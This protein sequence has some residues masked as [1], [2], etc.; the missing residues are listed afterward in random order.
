MRVHRVI[1]WSLLATVAGVLLAALLS[2]WLLRSD[3]G[4][5]WLLA[6][7]INVLPAGATLEWERIDGTLSGPLEIRD[8]HYRHEG[9]RF[10]A[11]R[12]RIDH[13]IWPLLSRRL[14]IHSLRL[15]HALLVL[16]VDDTP[17]EL[18]RW[19]DVL[20][21]LDL[22]VTVSVDKL[23]V[24]DLQV[25]RVAQSLVK[26]ERI[27]GGLDLGRGAMA[28][29]G[30]RLRSDRGRLLVA[31]EYLPRDNFRTA[32][33]G[34]VVFPAKPGAAAAW[35][36]L[37]VRGD[38]DYFVL[39]LDGRAPSPV[40][41]RLRLKDG[42]GRP[43]WQ[44]D[45]SSTRLLAA[46]LGLPEDAPYAFD[47]HALG[48]GGAATLR[49]RIARGD[50]SVAIEP[51]RLRLE[52]GVLSAAPLALR[53]EQGPL[54][55][56]GSLAL[57][58][59]SPSFDLVL[60][61][62]GLD[63]RPASAEQGAL[64]VRATGRVQVRG[65]WQAWTVAGAASLLRDR[66][67]A[68]LVLDGRGDARHLSLTS[69]TAST[70]TGRLQGQGEL[71]WQPRLSG[72][73]QADLGGFDPG[74][75]FPDYPGALNGRIEA[76]AA[77]DPQGRWQGT[78]SIANLRG[79]LRKRPLQGQARLQFSGDSG[80]GQLALRI[81][82]SRVEAGGRFGPNLDLQAAFAPLDLADLWPAAGGRLQ[83]RVTVRGARAAPAYAAQL[84]GAGLRWGDWS[85]ASLAANGQLPAQG[86]SGSL[87]VSASGFAVAGE[88]FDKAALQLTGSVASFHARA[89]LSAGLGVL[90]IEATAAGAGEQWQ[91]RLEQLRLAPRRGAAWRLQSAAG[92]RY[93]AGA[94][95][96]DR[97]CLRATSTDGELCAQASNTQAT[98]TGRGFPL[99]L[100]EPWLPDSALSI[101]PF[102]EL[103]LDGQ[104]NRNG[105]G[106]WRGRL[107]A[108]SGSGG[109]RLEGA[110][111]REVF[112][113]SDLRLELQLQQ[114]ELT[115]SLQASL[116]DG[117]SITGNAR[118]K[119]AASAPLQG[120]VHVQTRALDW[121]ELLSTDLASP[122]GMLDGKLVLAGELDAPRLSGDARLSQFSADLPSLGLN[123]KAGDFTLHGDA[124]GHARM[125]GQLAS[126]KGTLRVDG[127]WNLRQPDSPLE[128]TLR[129]EDITVAQTPDLDATMSPDLR[130]SYTRGRLQI[131][132]NVLVPGARVDLERLD[133]SV[134]PSADVVV[135]DPREPGA[136]SA[137][138]VDT[139]VQLRLGSAVRLHGFGLDG[140]LTGSL[141]VSDRPERPAIANGVL[142]IAGTYDAYGRALA[143]RRGRLSYVN[144]PYDDP[145]L[146]IQA[147]REF[148]QVTVGV[149]VRGTAHAPET[150]VTSQPAMTNAEALSWLL[151]G[152]PLNSASGEESRRI[153]ASA[154]ALSAGSNLLAQKIGSRLGLDS[155]GITETRAL[156][157]STFLVGK[158]I[159]PRLFVSYGLS[160]IGSGQVITLKY[161]LRHG[162]NVSVESS[163]VEAAAALNW[164]KEK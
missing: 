61:S 78:A 147:E 93:R 77:R 46:Q 128:L 27:D 5:D 139:D 145:T 116:P 57:E 98:L 86:A 87:R 114:P 137:F 71:A 88:R 6:R 16:P 74:Y 38:L 2:V 129:G 160:L 157:G 4:R 54:T 153:N 121:M 96:L 62:P 109:L 119:F 37:A 50:V 112:A 10:D 130:M 32:L 58:S 85:A 33:G 127:A 29:R 15:E 39:A 3:G 65:T 135:L 44:F 155:A 1:R 21:L 138:L 36:T 152:R 48:E 131:R 136:R 124:D 102:G 163:T 111:P 142:D 45:A 69:F 133:R 110:S 67:Q 43:H 75:F 34:R 141:H 91:G 18:P 22:P 53:L 90:A 150:T 8:I 95:E 117:G 76:T 26:I 120:Q 122:K 23:Q 125:S 94:I 66:Q 161:L 72:S 105:V 92:Y 100:A 79:A 126:G 28:L 104:F 118:T 59:R 7:V 162:L 41:L 11:R 113:Y 70:P 20:P 64:P 115:A 107:Q 108:R 99:S 73:L 123:L 154:L 158:Q 31:G 40:S 68:S 52:A 83:G 47:L 82:A 51:S 106:P 24:R 143:I 97:A 89:D 159:S 14:D 25:R 9:T 60:Q 149:R 132:G 80:A 19:P 35:A 101:R 12:L 140:S 103:D 42:R 84:T 63:L 30:I 164:H 56:N 156:G 55:L 148:D 146:D 17:L 144:S 134:S 49:G 151:L 13:G 81:G